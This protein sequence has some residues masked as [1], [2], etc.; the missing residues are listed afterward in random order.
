M[1]RS[2]RLTLIV[3]TLAGLCLGLTGGHAGR[4][5]DNPNPS[6]LLSNDGFEVGRGDV[7]V[8][9]RGIRLPG[10]QGSVNFLWDDAVAST[11]RHSVR[12]DAAGTARGIWSQTVLV[13][14]GQVY[15]ISGYVAFEDLAPNADC[16]LQVVFRD[17]ARKVLEFVDLARHDSGSR[18]F[19]L[20][21]PAR[22]LVRAPEGASHAEVNGSLQGPGTAWFDD[23]TFAPA[24]VGR[25][26]GTVTTDGEPLSGVRVTVW[27]DPWGQ[28]LE[29]WTAQDGSYVIDE[30]PV[31]H[32][33][34]IVI[35]EADGYRSRA[36]GD[37][38]VVAGAAT[39]IDFDLVPGA[40][41]LDDLEVGYGF[42]CQSQAQATVSLP[43]TAPLPANADGYPAAIRPYLDADA[44]VTSDDPA[45][46]RQAERILDSLPV[47]EQANAVTVARA[48]YEW[49]S[50]TVNH[51]AVYGNDRPYLDVTS[52]IW[53]TIQPG[54]WCWGRSF[55]DW[56]YRPAELMAEGTGIC[57]EHSWLSAAMLRALNIPARARVGSAQFWVF[58]SGAEGA[59]FEI[60]TNGGSN[61]YRQ[62]GRLG[63]GFGGST[64][65]VFYS[66]T[67]EPFLHED[68]DWSEAG[69]WRERH[70]W[71][72]VY[73]AT[74]E[75][76]AQAIQDL[77]T[78]A[79]TG[80]APEGQIRRRPGTESVEVHYSQIMLSR[81]SLANQ[82]VIDVRFPAPTESSATHDTG[83]WSYWTN[84][85]ECVVDVYEETLTGLP[86]GEAQTWR[87]IVFDV[88]SLIG[89]GG[90]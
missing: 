56:L 76:L 51:D 52:G 84:H 82:P 4:A 73:P 40:D 55:Y 27:G 83:E 31:S 48:V 75:G 5:T 1:F 14:P 9:W 61:T 20:D 7:P 64:L 38:D 85:P 37:V 35:T 23:L 87:H 60:A 42:I 41:A 29:T 49:I 77:G 25:L 53:Q 3:A 57:I 79:Q 81:L 80:T 74:D 43:E 11:G 6:N 22:M 65:P 44:Y 10:G 90:S 12:I 45:V 17:S 68:W 34:Y 54:G 78:F 72:E 89:E 66:A 28:P 67:S 18:G 46:I 15:E 50:T 59:W 19:E 62:T 58:T 70:P 8:G 24:P 16:H 47:D 71:G 2:L 39:V 21:F 26:A 86:S 63:S 69:L 13:E 30:V 32:P 33:R 88:S 36:A